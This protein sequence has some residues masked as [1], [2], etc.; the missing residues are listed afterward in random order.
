MKIF[1]YGEYFSRKFLGKKN[2]NLRK[3]KRA[4]DSLLPALYTDSSF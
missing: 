4:L 3:I 1:E 2:G